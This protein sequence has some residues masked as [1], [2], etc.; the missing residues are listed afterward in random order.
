MIRLKTLLAEQKPDFERRATEFVRRAQQMIND[1]FKKQYPNIPKPPKL[2]ITKG[3][4]YWR[5][6]SNDGVSRSAYV[7]LDTTNGD[8]LKPAGW[9]AP[10]KHARGNIFNSDY[11]IGGVTTFGGRYLR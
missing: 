7:F 8:V 10:A 5:V 6:V 11:G 4:R 9:K 3:K 2:E 1:H